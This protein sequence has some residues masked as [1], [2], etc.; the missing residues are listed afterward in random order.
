MAFHFVGQL[1]LTN[2]LRSDCVE[3]S[4]NSFVFNGVDNHADSISEV[5]PRH[6]LLTR[7]NT[8]PK[9]FSFLIDAVM[10]CDDAN[11][12]NN[13]SESHLHSS[14]AIFLEQFGA[15]LVV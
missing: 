2:G 9:G 3:R 4:L 12:R 11:I 1:L 13:L 5:N 6:P 10:V 14:S 15:L 7:A 8:R